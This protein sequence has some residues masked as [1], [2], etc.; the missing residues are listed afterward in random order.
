MIKELFNGR[1]GVDE[2]GVIYSLKNNAGNK[3]PVPKPM[4]LRQTREGYLFLN[5][6]VE[7]A[8][9]VIKKSVF[10][11]RL[12]ATAFHPNPDGKPE[13]NHLNGI[14]NNNA[15]SNLEWATKAENAMHAHATGL[16]KTNHGASGRFNE[17]HGKSKP[18]VQLTI[19]GIEI[20]RYPSLQEAAR[21]G[22]SQGNISS[23][24]AGNRKTHR[25][26]KWAFA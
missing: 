13:V 7:D 23:V 2:Q 11:H 22:Y 17:L 5:V 24:I 21:D 4:K 14:K 10:A 15:S 12:V 19:E 3:R 16:S 18:I 20:K 1:Y 6:Y 9:T 25:G 26:F 8:G